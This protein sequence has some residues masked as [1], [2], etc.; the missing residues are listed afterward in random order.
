MSAKAPNVQMQSNW[1]SLPIQ[2]ETKLHPDFVP[3]GDEKARLSSSCFE[4][5]ASSASVRGTEET[6]LFRLV[7]SLNVELED[8][9][10]TKA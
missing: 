4:L 8:K 1:W 2:L 6:D 5:S 7:S 3:E 10:N 9:E